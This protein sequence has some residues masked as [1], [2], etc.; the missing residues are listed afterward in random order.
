MDGIISKEHSRIR[1]TKIFKFVLE[2][3]RRALRLLIFCMIGYGIRLSYPM[4]FGTAEESAKALTNPGI[5]NSICI[6]F[7]LPIWFIGLLVAIFLPVAI[8][9][10]FI[11]WIFNIEN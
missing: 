3:I 5:F 8:C 9:V 6:L 2:F 4:F 11:Q 1:A 7:S 10:Q